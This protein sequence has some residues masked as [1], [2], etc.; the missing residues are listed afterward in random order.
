MLEEIISVPRK[1]VHIVAL[2]RETADEAEI[3]EMKELAEHGGLT[4]LCFYPIRDQHYDEGFT[5]GEVMLIDA[6]TGEI[7]ADVLSNLHSSVLKNAKMISV[8]REKM[9]ELRDE[10]FSCQRRPMQEA[11]V[12]DPMEQAGHRDMVSSKFILEQLD[13]WLE[14][15]ENGS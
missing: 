5:S 13:K 6:D 4:S 7:L 15:K 12:Y 14:V 3:K 8:P 11:G 2:V 1:V 9:Q 10:I